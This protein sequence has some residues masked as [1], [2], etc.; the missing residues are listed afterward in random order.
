MAKYHLGR[1]TVCLVVKTVN[2]AEIRYSAFRRY[3]RTAEEDDPAACINHIPQFLNSRHFCPP[4]LTDCGHAKNCVKI[5]FIY[6]K[7]KGDILVGKSTFKYDLMLLVVALTWSTGFIGT[8]YAQDYGMSSSLIV[9]FRMLFASAAMLIIFFPQIGRLTKVQIKHGVIAGIFMSAG[10][11]LQTIGMQYT[12]VSNNAF[13][14]TTNV[15]FVPFISW[16]L[17]KNVR[18]L[19]NFPRGRDWL[20]RHF[21][22]DSSVRYDNLFQSRRYSLPL[23]CRLL[24]NADCIYRICGQGV[25]S[26]IFLFRSDHS[27][28]CRCA[29]LFPSL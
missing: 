20:L 2:T 5:K 19:K 3:S 15:I 26:S 17:L 29:R 4:F 16:L 28:G 18:P 14:T 11:L 10:F 22:P 27:N 9:V 8:K 25:G 6:K 21:H 13:L 12:D 7:I 24:R 1:I 23:M